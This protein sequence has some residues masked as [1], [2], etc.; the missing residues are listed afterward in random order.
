MLSKKFVIFQ[1]TCPNLVRRS[2]GTKAAL[3]IYICE[4]SKQSILKLHYKSK[5][6]LESAAI[7]CLKKK[8]CKKILK[9]DF[10]QKLDT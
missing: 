8:R 7:L 9:L 5:Y 3:Q 4:L 6:R 1:S 10:M 2:N